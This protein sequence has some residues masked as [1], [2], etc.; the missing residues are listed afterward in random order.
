VPAPPTPTSSASATSPRAIVAAA[1]APLFAEADLTLVM[2]H[3]MP[4]ALALLLALNVYTGLPACVR[5]PTPSD[6]ARLAVELPPT[7][8]MPR[9]VARVY[10]GKAASAEDC[11]LQTAWLLRSLSALAPCLANQ[12]VDMIPSQ[13]HAMRRPRD[14]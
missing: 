11:A 1:V 13:Q 5:D 14:A 4:R 12:L 3:E 7:P 10:A 2:S 8:L 9:M 6:K